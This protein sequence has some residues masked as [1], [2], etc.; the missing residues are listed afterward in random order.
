E[1]V[2]LGKDPGELAR[3]LRDTLAQEDE[4][5]AR[6][7]T[8]LRESDGADGGE[9]APQMD[10]AAESRLGAAAPGEKEED[11]RNPAATIEEDAVAAAAR[12]PSMTEQLQDALESLGGA[13]PTLQVVYRGASKLDARIFET[14]EMADI[15]SKRVREIDIARSRAL[16]ALAKVRSVMELRTCVKGVK[17][18]MGKGDLEAA[19]EYIFRYRKA[20]HRKDE[21][22]EPVQESDRGPDVE[23]DD[24]QEPG[25]DG[26]RQRS[27]LDLE[28][29]AELKSFEDTL[30][31]AAL[32][33]LNEAIDRKN[34]DAVI[35]GCRVFAKLGQPKE[36]VT[37]LLDYRC[38]QLRNDV[39]LEIDITLA[40]AGESGARGA[41]YE[42]GQD[43]NGEAGPRGASPSAEGAAPSKTWLDLLAYLLNQGAAVIQRTSALVR[44]QFSDRAELQALVV[45]LVNAECD[46]LIS[47]ILR[48]FMEKRQVEDRVKLIISGADKLS[49]AMLLGSSAW[50]DAETAQ[51]DAILALDKLLDDIALMLKYTETYNQ[52][53]LAR[54]RESD[55][56]EEEHIHGGSG[57]YVNAVQELAGYYV[58]LEETYM[59]TAIQMALQ[60]EIPLDHVSATE[61]LADHQEAGQGVSKEVIVSSI[62][63]DSFYVIDSKCKDRAMATGHV[64]SLRTVVS[65]MVRELEE[66]VA[67]ALH[68]RVEDIREDTSLLSAQSQ[69]QLD[70]LRQAAFSQAQAALTSSPSASKSKGKGAQTADGNGSSTLGA[71]AQSGD[72]LLA[73]ETTLNTLSLGMTYTN[74]L[75]QSLEAFA[76]QQVVDAKERQNLE[77]RVDGLL[78]TIE[79]FRRIRAAGLDRMVN[80]LKPKLHEQMRTTLGDPTVSFELTEDEYLEQNEGNDPYVRELL[81]MAETLLAQTSRDL[82]L[83]CSTQLGVLVA[84]FV[85]RGLEAAVVS[86][87]FTP[88]GALLLD[89]QLRSIIKFFEVRF[90]GAARA[91]FRRLQQITDLLNLD[92]VEDVHDVYVEPETS[93]A[94]VSAAG[95]AAGSATGAAAA[96]PSLKPKE[97]KRVLERRID[98]RKEDIKRLKT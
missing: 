82:D 46:K 52:F 62:I 66:T 51:T 39:A 91:R 87:Y 21:D 18:C 53:I 31:R 25:S 6:I 88:F 63:E 97:V 8:A 76:L 94:V 11:S 96:G 28:L 32:E 58:V 61:G 59:T 65:S 1:V 40:N 19:S 92:R 23:K 34:D 49:E 48:A 4:L 13:I 68:R 27:E 30:R 98:F 20:A 22:E 78:E 75:R 64:N 84:E 14:K 60:K 10:G 83:D 24:E 56:V 90:G 54:R 89:R 55:M 73:P 43:E 50:F 72:D 67:A 93:S 77:S 42:Y 74:T 79:V 81:Q 80:L 86:K 5:K 36:G 26:D 37:R 7:T 9:A 45:S 70:R 95:S 33:Q 29:G 15:V 85:A 12:G 3:A 41:D 71:T 2:D 57:D 38:E 69:E 44:A 17:D 35:K 47:R 16:E